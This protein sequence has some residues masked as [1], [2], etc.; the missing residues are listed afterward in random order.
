MSNTK[1]C[2]QAVIPMVDNSAPECDKIIKETCVA[3]VSN[4]VVPIQISEGDSYKDILDKLL[5]YT[6]SLEDRIITLETFH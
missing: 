4:R 1:I 2:S 5:L 6:K 3:A